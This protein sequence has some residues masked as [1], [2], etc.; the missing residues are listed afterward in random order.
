MELITSKTPG[1]AAHDTWCADDDWHLL[2][3]EA[4][5]LWEETAQAGHAAIVAQQGKWQ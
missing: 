5:D 2:D 3:D 1:H 4:R